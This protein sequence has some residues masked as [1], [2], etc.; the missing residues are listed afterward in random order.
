MLIILF[1]I[2]SY[3]YIL[4][5]GYV[6]GQIYCFGGDTSVSFPSTPTLDENIYPLNLENNSGKK[7]ESM[8]SQWNKVLPFYPFETEK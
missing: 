3:I 8:I 1:Y 2:L 4:A 5:C 7:S 6:S